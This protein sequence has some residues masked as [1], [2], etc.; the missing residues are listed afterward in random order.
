MKC[1]KERPHG[2]LSLKNNFL[3]ICLPQSQSLIYLTKNL[4]ALSK[5]VLN[6]KD[7]KE[8]NFKIL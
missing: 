7:K 6:Q 5:D 8:Q 3:K 2:Q 1:F 4:K